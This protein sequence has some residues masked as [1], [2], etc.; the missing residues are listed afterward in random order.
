[1]GFFG[2]V[3]GLGFGIGP[4]AG[5]LI[6][7]AQGGLYRRTLWYAALVIGVIGA[8]CFV[9]LGRYLRRR[10]ARLKWEELHARYSTAAQPATSYDSAA[11][12]T[13]VVPGSRSQGG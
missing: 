4:L 5:G 2:L 9:V 3:W 1:M 6:L 10:A 13:P 11:T 7:S 8:L 12:G